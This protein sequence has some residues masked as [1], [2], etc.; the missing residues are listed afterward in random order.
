MAGSL[1]YL[2]WRGD[3]TFKEKAFNS[4]DA[5]LFASLIYLP[6]D[7]TA[8]G[9]SLS[10]VA[11]RLHKIDFF[12]DQMHGVTGAQIWLLPKSPRLGSVKIIDWTNRMEKKPHPLQFTAATFR[13]A[14][15]KLLIVYRGTD[16][17]MI[18]WNEDMN[19]NYMPE[20][21]GQNVAANYLQTMAQKY[22]HDQIY[23]A[24]H[25]KGGNFA[26]YALSAADPALQDRII[27][28]LS[29]DGP[30][31]FH[32]VTQTVGFKRTIHKMKTYLP[33]SSVIG[34]MLDHPERVLI[35][36]TSASLRDQ[37]DPRQWDVGRDSFVLADGLTTIARVLRHALIH[38]NHS[39]PDAKRGEMF[40]ALFDAFENSDISDVS[41]LTNHKISGTYR[42]SRVLMSLDPDMRQIILSMFNDIWHTYRTNM[43]LPFVD[44]EFQYYPKSNDSSKA[45][46]FYEFYDPSIPN[47]KLPNEVLRRREKKL[48]KQ[49]AKNTKDKNKEDK[50]EDTNK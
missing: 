14:K 22:P 44:G 40:S 24:G 16:S 11:Q 2:R 38:F 50:S 7:E 30:G 48:K 9:H 20:V 41:Q 39:I 15:S 33:E 46:I 21:Y 36:K 19:M 28:A 29:F 47:L 32:Q 27:K 49:Q 5:S 8:A 42:L 18:G 23:L 25:S 4:V 35:V 12:Q 31:F 43:N 17:S 34:T 13:L 45:P 26:Q 6:V 3:L 10:E 37:H 1:D